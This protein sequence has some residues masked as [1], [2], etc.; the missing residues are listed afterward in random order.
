MLFYFSQAIKI[1]SKDSEEDHILTD[2][3][4]VKM[5]P[6]ISYDNDAFTLD[7]SSSSDCIVDVR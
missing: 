5:E 2:Q 3:T 4:S 7:L 6:T 1:V